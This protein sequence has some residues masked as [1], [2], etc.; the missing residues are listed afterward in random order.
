MKRRDVG[1][2]VAVISTVSIITGVVD[3]DVATAIA[4]AIAVVATAVEHAFH[5][6]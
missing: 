5:L 4:I 2:V 1:I 6:S 3:V